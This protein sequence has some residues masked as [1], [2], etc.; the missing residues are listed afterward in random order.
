MCDNFPAIVIKG[1]CDYADSHKIKKWQKHVAPSAAAWMKAFL[2]E[3]RRI[4]RP[5]SRQADSSE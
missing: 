2:K 3:W 1:V 4:D 5:V